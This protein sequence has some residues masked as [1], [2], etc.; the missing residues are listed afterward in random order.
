MR[1]T[2]RALLLWRPSPAEENFLNI[3]LG[4]ETSLRGNGYTSRNPTFTDRQGY[5]ISG[6]VTIDALEPVTKQVK[7]FA[8]YL[9]DGFDPERANA[10]FEVR[11]GRLFVIATRLIA[12][13]EE[14][15]LAYGP[16]YTG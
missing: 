11:N 1:M 15:T 10:R 7:C 16:S 9:N 5:E 4:I 2:W 8:G 14:I 12:K 3:T 6:G 13:N